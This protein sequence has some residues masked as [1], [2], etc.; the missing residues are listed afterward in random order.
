MFLQ[1]RLQVISYRRKI[2]KKDVF[3]SDKLAIRLG[4]FIGHSYCRRGKLYRFSY[5]LWSKRRDA[6]YVVAH[7]IRLC[8]LWAADGLKK[9]SSGCRYG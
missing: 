7:V 6:C 1:L 2:E 5:M 4:D 3:F 9:R 8:F